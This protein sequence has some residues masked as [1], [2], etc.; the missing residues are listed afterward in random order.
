MNTG[1]AMRSVVTFFRTYPHFGPALL[2][3]ALGG[4][5]LT[6]TRFVVVSGALFGAGASLLG[7]WI[8]DFNS[9]KK[10]QA[11]KSQR[12]KDAVKFLAP[13]LVR[14]IMRLL[15]LQER[16]II[17]YSANVNASWGRHEFKL[18][19]T[20]GLHKPVALGDQKED[21]LPYLPILYPNASQFK[22]ING[23]KAVK[24]VVYYDSLFDLEL[25]VKDWWQREGQLPSNIFNQISHKAEKSLSL[26]LECLEEF[27][28]VQGNYDHSHSETLAE[29]INA[30]QKKALQTREHCYA[31][32]IKANA[33]KK[34]IFSKGK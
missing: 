33:N 1:S 9:Q 3:F 26:A 8:S 24:L 22:E 17:N 4:A 12:E 31:V 23:N 34:D 19:L 13:E 25:F 11:S 21:F 20:T 14:T 32:F 29:R 30:A 2:L 28:I 6:T 5:F 27:E 7:A 10:E 18:P 15:A 16:A